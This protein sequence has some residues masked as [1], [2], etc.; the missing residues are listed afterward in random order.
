M[1]D[2]RSPTVTD[3]NQSLCDQKDCEL[4]KKGGVWI[5][6]LCEFEYKGSDRNRFLNCSSCITEVC[7]ECK[8]WNE[9]TVAEFMA[10]TSNANEASESNA[11]SRRS[12]G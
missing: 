8:E 3:Q 12:E 11:E 1:C 4:R 9:D 2:N 6:C 7:S 10:A 5:C